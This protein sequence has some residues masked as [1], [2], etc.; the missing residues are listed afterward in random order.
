MR[1]ILETIGS[2]RSQNFFVEVF[3][4]SKPEASKTAR[5]SLTSAPQAIINGRVSVDIAN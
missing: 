3:E 1:E 4:K 2:I 5:S